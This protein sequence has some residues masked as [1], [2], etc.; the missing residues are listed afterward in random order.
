MDSVK[1][2]AL[3]DDYDRK[4]QLDAEQTEQPLLTMDAVSFQDLPETD[5]NDSEAGASIRASMHE[6]IQLQAIRQAEDER[7][8]AI[9]AEQAKISEDTVY[10]EFV[11]YAGKHGI[12]ELPSKSELL[13]F[14]GLK[15][16]VEF[17]RVIGLV[18]MMKGA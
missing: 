2:M 13:G 16:G 5:E 10:R 14:Y 18:R 17:D 4:P 11:E 1:R 9:A 12:T 8:R 15:A 3:G 7:Q 6:R